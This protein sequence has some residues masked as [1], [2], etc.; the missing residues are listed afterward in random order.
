MILRTEE[1]KRTL[2]AMDFPDGSPKEILSFNF[3]G[4][5]YI[6]L[7]WSPDGRFIYFS[8]GPDTGYE[9]SLYRVPRQGGDA[10][11]LGL[12]MRRFQSLSVNPDGRRITFASIP[13]DGEFP[14]IWV[15]ENFLPAIGKK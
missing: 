7:A 4:R 15:M 3:T 8:K 10:Q 12:K 5:H 13:P 9:W 2:V 14:Q 6:D 1:N 11:D